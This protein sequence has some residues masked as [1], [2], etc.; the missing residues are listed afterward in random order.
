MFGSLIAYG[1]AHINS[2]LHVYQIIFLFFG[3]ITIAFAILI[4]FILP[5]S[6]I[7]ARFLKE[8]DKL[9]AI[10]RLRDN[11]QGVETREWKWSHVREALLKDYKTWLWGFM[12][13]SVSVPSGG[14]STFNTL[15][16][17]DFGFDSF[18]TLLFNIPQGAVQLLAILGG[19]FIA[20]KTRLKSPVLVCL[21]IPPIIG[22]VIL[23]YVKRGPDNKGI[24]LFAYYIIS[25]YPGVTPLVYSFSAANTA[26]ETK[27]KVTTGWLFMWQ[28]AGNIVGPQLYT[29]AEA[30][31]YRRGLLSNLALFVVLI[32]LYAVQVTYLF[33][34]NKKQE[35]RRVAAGK[36]AKIQDKSMQKVQVRTKDEMD[37]PQAD[38]AFDDLTDFENEDFVYVY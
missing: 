26:G 17:K 15:I 5:D 8:E 35:R 11:Q 21:S 7:T 32:G 4:F 18:T 13:F 16:L 10:E 3:S 1:I 12:M 31:L 2:P 28:C 36:I 14:I 33:F 30:P 29:T 20:T 37:A 27:K 9:I 6:P 23:L 25:V 38:H 24:L 22:C 34:L 19:A